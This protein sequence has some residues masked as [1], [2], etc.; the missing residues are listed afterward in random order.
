MKYKCILEL[1]HKFGI[2]NN[3]DFLKIFCNIYQISLTIF[4][5][6]IK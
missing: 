5:V 2:N 6:F 1:I 4:V 3:I